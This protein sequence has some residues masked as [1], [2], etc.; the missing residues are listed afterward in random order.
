ML[1]GKTRHAPAADESATRVVSPLSPGQG[2][3]PLVLAPEQPRPPRI[4]IQRHPLY[5]T[6]YDDDDEASPGATD[7]CGGGVSA[8]LAASEEGKGGV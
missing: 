3:R 6:P 7:G 2:R 1:L 5:T 8:G 4:A